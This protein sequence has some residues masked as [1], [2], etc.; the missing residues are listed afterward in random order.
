MPNNIYNLYINNV[1]V[2][3]YST[4]Q[5]QLVWNEVRNNVFPA[6]IDSQSP[7]AIYFVSK[8]QLLLFCCVRIEIVVSLILLHTQLIVLHV[9]FSIH[10]PFQYKIIKNIKY[11]FKILR[12]IKLYYYFKILENIRNSMVEVYT[13][14]HNQQL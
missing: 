12:H 1:V 6:L 2:G 14:Y 4:I 11:L 10:I 13:L 5:K 8:N 9:M 7:L 3:I